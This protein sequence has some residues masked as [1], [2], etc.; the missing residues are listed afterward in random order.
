MREFRVCRPNTPASPVAEPS[1]PPTALELPGDPLAAFPASR[2]EI[3]IGCARVSTIGQNLQQQID[4]LKAAGCR[5]VFADKRSGKTA[6]RPELKAC[7]AFLDAGDTLVVPS[8]D[9]YGRSLQDLI[10]M[11]A[12][13]RGR[14]IGFTSLVGALP[15]WGVFSP[16][17]RGWACRG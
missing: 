5:K 16:C 7:H 10:A 12:E 11:V 13:L 9:R 17:I 1:S 2:T 8:L 4:A 15:G 3:R 6:A 14:Q